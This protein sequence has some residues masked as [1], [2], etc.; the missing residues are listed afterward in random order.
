MTAI[1]SAL[2]NWKALTA[3]L[4][5]ASLI[6]ASLTLALILAKADARHWRKQADHN[7]A[8]YVGEQAKHALTRQSLDQLADVLAQKNEESI[9][10]AQLFEAAKAADAKAIAAADARARDAQGRIATLTRI[11]KAQGEDCPV[12]AELAAQLEGL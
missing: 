6:L 10:R 12:P 5:L 1:T 4:I 11:G 2:R 7:A 3:G 9:A 8:L